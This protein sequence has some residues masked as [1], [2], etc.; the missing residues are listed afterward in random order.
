MVTKKIKRGI[1]KIWRKIGVIKLPVL[2]KH[3]INE[4]SSIYTHIAAFL[5]SN[6][7]DVLLPITLQDLFQYKRKGLNWKNIHAHWVISDELIADINNTDGLIIGGGGLFLK[8][9]N[10]NQL[11]G[12]QWSCSIES[13]KKIS[14]PIA[15]FAAG[16]NRFQGQEDFDP[17]FKE[18]IKLLS[19]KAVYIG[20]RNHGSINAIRNYLP[21]NIHNKIRFQPCMTTLISKIYPNLFDYEKKEEF[22]VLNC[23]FDRNNLR[24]G[25]KEDQILTNIALACKELSKDY[26]IKYYAHSE[27]DLRMIPIL[28][29]VRLKFELV[30]FK[31]MHPKKIIKAY[32]KP[33]LVIGMR[34]HAQMIPFGCLTPIISLISHDKMQWFLD[35]INQTDW[36]VDIKDPNLKDI[37]VY[38]SKNILNN[39]LKTIEIIKEEQD[40]LL[41]I[42]IKN[43]NDFEES[44]KVYLKNNTLTA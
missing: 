20:L 22:I 36:G 3:N 18:H 28:E 12:W 26:K 10:P 31:Y 41:K 33:S 29:R 7:G 4:K 17:I 19:E 25:E 27:K 1:D 40:K 9:T 15:I 13:L 43:V 39:K 30:N 21:E 11:S 44:R 14:V 16:Y 24:F 34:G 35:D 2:A 38:K 23:A 32:S 37:I 8:D 6:A 5:L 42:S